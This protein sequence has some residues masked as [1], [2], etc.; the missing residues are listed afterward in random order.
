MGHSIDLWG[1]GRAPGVRVPCTSA[2]L[3]Q[4]LERG[5]HLAA[6]RRRLLP[7]G[8]VT[9]L[10]ELVVMNE[11]GIG[12]FR[13][14]PRCLIQLVRIGAHGDRKRHAFRSEK[15]KLALDRKTTRLNSSHSQISYAVLCLNN[16]NS[17]T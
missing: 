11:L 16:N 2:R 3:T 7:G 17:S 9:A 12:L 13:P 4:R 15:G 10:V 6:E 5:A 14:T 8:E 1:I